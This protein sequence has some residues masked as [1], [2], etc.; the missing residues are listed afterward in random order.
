MPGLIRTLL[1]RVPAV[2]RQHSRIADL[3]S[4]LQQLRDQLAAPRDVDA[5]RATALETRV[6]DLREQLGALATNLSE[7]HG[8]IQRL[9]EQLG[10][11]IAALEAAGAAPPGQTNPGEVAT[12]PEPAVPPRPPATPYTFDRLLNER[13]DNAA[14]RLLFFVH[15]PKAAGYTVTNFLTRNDYRRIELHPASNSFFHWTSEQRWFERYHDLTSLSRHVFTGHFRLDHTIFTRMWIPFA[16]VTMLRHPIDR[17]LSAYNF[18]LRVSH[19]PWHDNVVNG[20]MSFVEFAGNFAS[21]F[22]PQYSYFD[23][24]G[25]GSLNWT[26]KK[27][28]QECL[29]NLLTKVAFYGF[30]DRFDEFAA[31]LA[32]LLRLDVMMGLH[33]VNVTEEIPDKFGRPLKN[34]V[35]DEERRS[36]EQVLRDDLSFYEQAR[37]EYDRR[38]SNPQLQTILRHTA[39]L[40][41]NLR[42]TMERYLDIED[43][44]RPGSSAFKVGWR[45]HQ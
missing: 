13:S 38:L 44:A 28:A 18:T 41:K 42:D 43:P 8:C 16:T 45:P 23:D 19:S 33:P 34:C 10:A 37:S 27:T 31:I 17:M 40:I 7:Q 25:T 36:L 5:A 26:G 11:R 12:E 24:S 20:G 4:Q 32:Y 39:P 22:G 9:E 14:V 30:T 1:L 3:E 21:A 29:H 35:T 15:V 6:N 2:Q